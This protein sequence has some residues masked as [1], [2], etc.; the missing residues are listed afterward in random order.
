MVLEQNIRQRHKL[1][2]DLLVTSMESVSFL[3]RRLYV[4]PHSQI[5][6]GIPL[7]SFGHSWSKQVVCVCL[8][9]NSPDSRTLFLGKK[10]KKK[11]NLQLYVQFHKSLHQI[12]NW[13]ESDW[14]GRRQRCSSW[15]NTGFALQR[16]T[17]FL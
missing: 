1:S 6:Q 3:H 7:R 5:Q 12:C 10:R 17:V 11:E 13:L 8:L 2:Q 16:I 9:H 4:Y 14:C 15:I